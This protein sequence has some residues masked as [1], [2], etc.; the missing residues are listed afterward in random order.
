[1][2]ERVIRD[3]RYSVRMLTKSPLFTIAAVATLALGI[4][5]NAATFSAVTGILLRP[6]GGTEAPDELVQ[7]Y[8]Q[9]PGMDYGSVSIPHYQDLRD[10]S[11]D[12]FESSA[13]WFFQEM[14]LASE[15]QSE[16][17]IGMLVSA[18]FF[19]TYGVTAQL[20]RTFIPGEEDRGPGAH[21]VAVL[22][23]SFWQTRFGGDRDIIGRTVN[24][25]G[26][27]YEI[28]GVAPAA[29]KG[30]ATFADAPLYVPIMMQPLIGQFDNT[31]S[32]GNNMMNFVGR[33][34]DGETIGRAEQVLDG[35]LVQLRDEFPGEYD[36]QLGHTLIFQSDAGIHPM[37]RTAQI[38]MSA[39]MM[40]V[41]GLLLLIACVNVANL[42]LARARERRR[43]MGIRLSLGASGRSLVQQ[44]LTESLVFSLLAGLAGLGLAAIATRMLSQVRPPIDGPWAFQ[45]Q[46]DTSVLW[47]TLIVSVI[48]GIVFG[49]APALQA[50]R[51]DTFAAVKNAAEDKPGRSRVSSGLVV[52][53]MALSLLLLISSGLFLRSLQGATE[54]DPGFD[55]PGGLVLTS[56]DPG[57]QGYD[58]ARA[59]EFLN[60]LLED[61]SALPEVESA[62]LTTTVPLGLGGSDR[63]VGIPGYEF[64]EG[65]LRSIQYA[66]VTEGFFDAMGIRFVEGRPF[67]RQDDQDASPVI[68]VNQRFAERF[69]PDQS[70]VGKIV[71]TA[72]VEHEVVGVVETGKYRSLGEVPTEHMY[73]PERQQFRTAVAVVARAR[74]GTDVVLRRIHETVRAMDPDMPV[75]DAR[76]MEDH[77][78]L[79]LLPA[80]LGG[81]VLG[82]FGVLGL[83]LAAVGIYG[84]MAYSVA[85]RTKE[86]GVRVALGANRRRVL[87]LVLREGM[88]LAMFGT[89]LGLLAA[90][91][92]ARLVSG[93]LYNVSAFDPVAFIGVPLLLT[94]VAALAVY[95]P[96]RRAATLDPIQ[97]LKAE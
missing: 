96:A 11:A 4:G 2:F 8:R 5:L 49:L 69:W 76:T 82:M 51:S 13:A 89:V 62:G 55:S 52:L 95:L 39:V 68:I 28:V 43:E 34:R 21:P 20:G 47:F 10:R 57:L 38:G 92:A 50:A 14:S 56:V 42:F 54:I 86:I 30:P 77:M 91:A 61:V 87:R 83:I 64:A 93:M 27:P 88:R 73:L 84:V 35:I 66:M 12:V 1:M 53:Q 60:R 7:V 70:A 37:F 80:R 79:A 94:A 85:Q 29:F 24:L 58:E 97:A 81:S 63:G 18:N 15:G 75:Y 31:Q 67:E 26:S 90:A 17:F 74:T 44:L 9:W 32:R 19:Q 59:R 3:L 48:A 65:E 6:L 16:R 71:Q 22:G 78:G 72:G 40:V 25:N 46:L 45:V 41:V 36:T 23:H 33:L